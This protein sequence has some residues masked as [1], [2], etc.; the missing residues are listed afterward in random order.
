MNLDST[1]SDIKWTSPLK[2]HP[3]FPLFDWYSYTCSNVNIVH[4]HFQATSSDALRRLD[5]ISYASAFDAVRSIDGLWWQVLWQLEAMSQDRSGTVLVWLMTM[6]SLS[7]ENICE[8][9]SVWAQSSTG[10]NMNMP[11]TW[12]CRIYPHI[13]Y[14]FAV[15]QYAQTKSLCK[16]GLCPY[17]AGIC[18]P[19]LERGFLV[20]DSMRPERVCLRS[21]INSCEKHGQWQRALGQLASFDD[22]S[23]HRLYLN[24]VETCWM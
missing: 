15:Q 13:D 10:L 2:N 1:T 7:P 4:R 19:C 5:I 22:V 11:Y 12:T 6:F 17:H 23:W 24:G 20:Q 18:W 21:V 9:P 14:G 3:W 8:V 16:F